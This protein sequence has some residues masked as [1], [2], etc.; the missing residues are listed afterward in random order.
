MTNRTRSSRISLEY[1]HAL[2]LS[3]RPKEEIIFHVTTV[4]GND[5][6]VC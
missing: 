6:S 2:Y 3:N 4:E 1:L 5:V